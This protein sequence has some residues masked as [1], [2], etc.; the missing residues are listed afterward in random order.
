[1]NKTI[2]LPAQ[3]CDGSPG[4][5]VFNLRPV[6]AIDGKTD[7]VPVGIPK[8]FTVLGGYTPLCRH[9]DRLI[10]AEGSRIMA[11]DDSSGKDRPGPTAVL[12]SDALCAVDDKD[13]KLLVMTAK[14][15]TTL[16][17]SDTDINAEGS[18]DFP[19]VR[20]SAS[21]SVQF[22]SVVASRSLSKSYTESSR[23]S[24]ADREGLV[25]DLCDAYREI[26]SK[27][28]A[29]GCYVQ[30]VLAR[31][32]LCRRDGT[33]AFVSPAILLSHSEGAQCDTPIELI[34]A[35]R[36]TIDTYT[37]SAK[38]WK[39][40]VDIPSRLEDYDIEIWLSPLFHPY[41]PDLPADIGS[42]RSGTSSFVSVS[43]PGSYCGIS[44]HHSMAGYNTLMAAIARMDALERKVAVLGGSEGSF[45][46]DTMPDPD[47]DSVARSLRRELA[48]KFIPAA[49][50]VRELCP[51][52]NMSAC[53]VASS[54]GA[55]LW[56]GLKAL[57]Y[58]GYPL[59]TFTAKSSVKASTVTVAISFGDGKGVIRREDYT[60]FAP[61]AIGP[62]LSYPSSRAKEMTVIWS[63]DGEL[64]KSTYPLTPD[65]SG[66]SAIYVS[67]D[68]LPFTPERVSAAAIP[69]LS[70]DGESLD[71][72]IAVAHPDQA[73]SIIRTTPTGRGAVRGLVTVPGRDQ[74]W[75]FG[76]SRFLAACEEGLVSVTVGSGGAISARCIAEGKV[77][78]TMPLCDD[79]VFVLVSGR[80]YH[81]SVSGRMK[82]VSDKNGYESLAYNRRRGELWCFSAGGNTDVYLK[83]YRRTF[84]STLVRG[85]E[86]AVM[87][88]DRPYAVSPTALVSLSDE[89]AG[90]VEID[91]TVTVRTPDRIPMRTRCAVFDISGTQA[92]IY[93]GLEAIGIDATAKRPVFSRSVRG[94]LRS[95]MHVP[96]FSSPSSA[97]SLSLRGCVDNDFRI[98]AFDL[99][100]CN[101]KK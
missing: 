27:A 100:V 71:D 61:D 95:G 85:A 58:K 8:K 45:Y 10:A 78:P 6:E 52:H 87:T 65:A 7:L 1:M 14:G 67:P 33:T 94:F 90:T 5:T 72:Y 13:G 26:C 55:I 83:N 40:R 19:P 25:G 62:V 60:D 17:V 22:S 80:P 75:E 92:D 97:F 101:P 4:N 77:S 2:S 57:P 16:N 66:R 89:D 48:K 18:A 93:L 51:P 30:P 99:T 91:Y 42:V 43:L 81:V 54:P 88:G 28:A 38:S 68:F 32:R 20:L 39:L 53:S 86:S 50:K 69:D 63:S 15:L 11:F 35:D 29:A 46:T 41:N 21:D 37:L 3:P 49:G 79:G 76:R 34:S 73:L 98:H 59:G 82:P 24:K 36:K 96:A 9:K 84:Y 64:H 23:L 31:Y 12:D 47:I 74:S 44:R 56:G 70:D